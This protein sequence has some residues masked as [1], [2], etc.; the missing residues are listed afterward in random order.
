VERLNFPE[1]KDEF[2]FDQQKKLIFDIVRKKFIP[3]TPEE[4]VRQHCVCFLNQYLDIP[5]GR[6]AIERSLNFNGLTKRFDI[7][8]FSSSGTPQLLIECKAPE[9]PLSQKTLIQAGV[10]NTK[11]DTPFIW[12]TN[13][14]QHI[15]LKKENSNYDLISFPLKPDELF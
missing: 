15:W 3:L 5:L 6:M 12:L 14:F 2:Q 9:I 10:Y 1:L 13:G 7:V 11:L 8:A 4:W